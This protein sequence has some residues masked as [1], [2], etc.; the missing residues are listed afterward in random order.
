MTER[1]R[2]DVWV[3]SSGHRLGKFYWRIALESVTS[4]HKLR[5]S[6][7]DPMNAHPVFARLPRLLVTR[8]ALLASLLPLAL[9]GQVRPTP[10]PGGGGGAVITPPIVITPLPGGG[11]NAGGGGGIIGGGGGIIGGGNN[12]AT[13]TIVSPAG[14][15]VGATVNATVI[16]GQAGQS[17]TSGVT[18]QWNIS[19][20]RLLSD[21]RAAT[22]Q[23]MADGVGTVN[24]SVNVSAA[25][26]AFAPTATVAIVSAESAG[27]V[28][29]TATVA[30][31][32]TSVT[33]T[34]PPAVNG[35]RSFRWTVTGQGA[36]IVT[37]QGTNSITF[38]PGQAGLKEVTC[39][40]NLQNVVTVPIRALVV[41]QGTGAPVVVTVNG[42]SGGG[43]YPAGSR[44][45]IM[46]DPPASGQVFDRWTGT[47]EVLGT[48]ALLP[49]LSSTAITVPTNAV[50]LTATYKDAPVWTPTVL[51]NFNPQTQAGPN[52]TTTTV[53]TTL[54]YQIPA[55][56]VGLVFLLHATGGSATEWF[57]R[58]N[59]LLLARDLVAAGYGVAALHSVNRT[60][61]TWAQPAVLA[62]NLDALNHAAAID[63][64]VSLNALGATK[65]VFFLGHAAGANAAA[66]YADLLATATP[67]RPVKGAVLYLSAG[68]DTLAVT[69]KV[70]QFFALASGDN[71][72]GA[73]GLQD[74][75]DASQLL[76]GR[77][78]ATAV[79]ANTVTPLYAGR[80][81]SLGITASTFTTDD[82]SAIWTAV[83][84]AGFLDTNNYPKAVPSTAALTAALPA[85]YRSRVTDIGAEIAIAAAEREFFADA[86]ARVINFITGRAND[87]PVAAPGRMVNLSTRSSIAYLGDSLAV[88]F[89]ISGTAQATLL[90]R[91]IGPTLSRFGVSGAIPGLRLELNRGTNVIASNEGWDRP[92]G[93]G[94]A[95]PAQISQAAAGV[96]A[97]ALAPGTLDAAV[98]VQLPPGTYTAN[99]TGVG[100]AIGEVMAEVY[101]VSRNA[102]RLTNL[103]TLSRINNDGDL[104]IPGIV[105]AGNNPRT[106]V[107][108]AV[109]QGLTRFG[110]TP[111]LVLGDPRISILNGNQTVALNNNWGQAGTATLTA[112]FPAV[113][114]FPLNNA[115]DSALLEAL[116]PGS[117]TLQAGATP[118]GGQ[119]PAGAVIPN[120]IGS[121]LVEVYEV[122]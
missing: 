107:V 56:P 41:A 34:V 91:G 121:V 117:Y 110:L 81:R 45:D 43:T 52:N 55:N 103:S 71:V 49:L 75:R 65:P 68:I 87:A 47:T 40:V 96:G 105:I 30:S 37:G 42:G 6:D 98:L 76:L 116:A 59:Q 61:G 19:G 89:N 35:D 20:G 119:I 28:T 7:F 102:T 72:L 44:V 112:A 22:I 122:P 32:A 46:A 82:A 4:K 100:G 83:K 70:P 66:R 17:G 1:Q 25:G 16:L 57:E 88:G 64:L 26:T 62:N 114:A 51:T 90:I 79:V 33:A 23:F 97:F 11:G 24:L 18:Y 80:F 39:N 78:V 74:A 13:P 9:V 58:P 99:I 92:G 84:N 106:L 48:G 15:L 31:N 115:A 36:Q 108:R 54:H 12:V 3:L 93:A 10:L 53:S 95:T 60:Q 120:Q 38:R 86:N 77:G 21:A 29:T 85:A 69:S 118:L 14:A 50:T 63:R 8:L 109:S 94:A 111:D 113:G 67:A 104:L 101:D 73:T 27:S 5:P 2:E